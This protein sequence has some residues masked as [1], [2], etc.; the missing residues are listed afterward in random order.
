MSTDQQNNPLHGLKTETMVKE[1]VEHYGWEIL[2]TAMRFH[3]FKTNPTIKGS[4]KFLRNT[5]WAREKL[6]SFYLSRFKRMPRATE[7]EFGMPS[8]ERGFPE[9]IVPRKP[10]ELTIESIE[11]SQAKSASAHEER[12]NEK[13]A[14]NRRQHQQDSFQPNERAKDKRAAKK[15]S[16]SETVAYD[17]S[18][19]WNQ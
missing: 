16:N 19:P 9:H 5:Q 13:R 12:S 10:M 1:L 4:V 8:R 15:E 7:E 6:E 2:F 14:S 3:C 18:N 11:L 17:P